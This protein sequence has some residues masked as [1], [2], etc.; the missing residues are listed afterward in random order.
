M[1]A[2][3]KSATPSIPRL[4]AF[5]VAWKSTNPAKRA[6]NGKLLV[7]FGCYLVVVASQ[8]SNVASQSLRHIFSDHVKITE[9]MQMPCFWTRAPYLVF[10]LQTHAMCWLDYEDLNA[11]WLAHNDCIA[12]SLF[13]VISYTILS[14]RTAD[15]STRLLSSYNTGHRATPASNS[16]RVLCHWEYQKAIVETSGDYCCNEW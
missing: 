4:P 3:D 9:C 13:T 12:C 2:I 11:S 10:A 15:R 8:G 5:G 1:V 7:G 14:T 6:A 16:T